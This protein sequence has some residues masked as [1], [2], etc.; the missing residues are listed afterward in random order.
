MFEQ[1][2]QVLLNF[3][4]PASVIVL[5]LMV[6]L[7][8]YLFH[9][10]SKYGFVMRLVFGG[11]IIATFVWFW[12]F[13]M[14][15]DTFVRNPEQLAR[16]FYLICLFS[17]KFAVS[18]AVNTTGKI[19]SAVNMPM[20]EVRGHNIILPLQ[21]ASGV[22]L[23]LLMIVGFW[24]MSVQRTTMEDQAKED[25][26]VYRLERIEMRFVDLMAK[27]DVKMDSVLN[28]AK[29]NQSEIEQGKVQ[30]REQ[31]ALQRK[32][33]LEALAAK[34]AA[35]IAKRKLDR[36]ENEAKSGK[37]IKTKKIEKSTPNFLERTYQK[38]LKKSSMLFDSSTAPPPVIPNYAT[39]H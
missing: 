29:S 12:T 16:C 20:V 28:I 38:Y 21:V 34:R 6:P 17:V 30:N 31:I 23:S 11:L 7:D 10:M 22:L 14:A 33:Y 37:S 2:Y 36:A 39:T 3:N 8:L 4:R 15:F 25:A 9:R 35:L 27:F 1:I 26:Q 13:L 18:I 24:M 32:T 5:C 19:D